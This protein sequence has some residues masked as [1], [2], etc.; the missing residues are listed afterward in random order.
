LHDD[1][2]PGT[3]FGFIEG[4]IRDETTENNLVGQELFGRVCDDV[5]VMGGRR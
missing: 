4:D 3:S 5:D 2:Q 1:V